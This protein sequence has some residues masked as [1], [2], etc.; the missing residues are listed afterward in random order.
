MFSMKTAQSLAYTDAVVRYMGLYKAS[1]QKLYA[2]YATPDSFRVDFESVKSISLEVTRNRLWGLSGGLC[3]SADYLE[4]IRRSCPPSDEQDKGILVD[5]CNL[6][7]WGERYQFASCKR[8][9]TIA[10]STKKPNNYA[11]ADVVFG[12]EGKPEYFSALNIPAVWEAFQTSLGSYPSV[13]KFLS[14]LNVTPG[15]IDFNLLAAFDGDFNVP[16][17]G[18]REDY[19]DWYKQTGVVSWWAWWCSQNDVSSILPKGAMLADGGYW[20]AKGNPRLFSHWPSSACTVEN[21]DGVVVVPGEKLPHDKGFSG[22]FRVVSKVDLFHQDLPSFTLPGVFSFFVVD[23]DELSD[24]PRSLSSI[25]LDVHYVG[26]VDKISATDTHSIQ[27][28]H[29]RL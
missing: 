15:S 17:A 2:V 4:L 7:K 27:L 18:Y 19:L 12:A 25:E 16:V 28:Y 23:F 21:T 3:M 8:P 24:N 29:E 11:V 5:L 6:F 9:R 13:R 10:V 26:T 1:L 20:L 14:K 22:A